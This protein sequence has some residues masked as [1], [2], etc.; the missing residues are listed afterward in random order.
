[1]L[2]GVTPLD[3]TS[4]AGAASALVVV[5]L[6]ACYVPARRALLIDPVTALADQ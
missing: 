2:Y 3:P 4:V 5:A 6:I 1:M